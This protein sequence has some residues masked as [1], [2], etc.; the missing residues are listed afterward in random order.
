MSAGPSSHSTAPSPTTHPDGAP[1]P[2]TRSSEAARPGA[3]D[4]SPPTVDHRSHQAPNADPAPPPDRAGRAAEPGLRDPEPSAGRPSRRAPRPDP[5]PPADLA[6]P[7]A[8]AAQPAP[9]HGSEPAV[10]PSRRAPDADPGP[11]P[12]RSRRDVDAAQP[13]Q[14]P[15]QP[16]SGRPP[17]DDAAAGSGPPPPAGPG[18]SLRS[19]P[20]PPSHGSTLGEMASG[21]AG[22]EDRRTLG[23][24]LMAAAVLCFT[25]IDTSA[26]WL[27]LAGLP[28]LQV[29]FARYAGHFLLSLAA[30]M[31]S[32]G[33]GA[34]RSRRPWLQF[35]RSSF[36]L[37][38]TVLNFAALAYLPLTLT[39]TIM[40][41]GPIVV[42]LLSVPILGERIGKRRM[43][44]I[45]VGFAGVTIAVQPWGA[46]FHP[47]IG[48][49]IGALISASLYFVLTRLL[50]GIESNA[51]SQLWSSGLATLAIAPFAIAQWRWPE[52]AGGYA[53][54]VGIGVFGMIGHSLVTVASR[55]AD[56]ST[57]APV[58]Y[59]QFLFAAVAGIVVFATPP[60]VWTLLGGA[61]IVG[62][63]VYIWRRERRAA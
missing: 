37:G 8:G 17:R 52:T 26:K 62:S 33:P 35:L 41:A 39:T 36:L 1:A 18:L 43:A 10:H 30:F 29:V 45:V 34:F 57:L 63:G 50:A 60:T 40:F 51:T 48:L 27:I 49:S 31:P 22:R 21:V 11:P 61:V 9:V 24:G 47:A 55:F 6:H 53:V 59:I 14:L 20:V 3:V 46:G 44:A 23:L 7:P 56:A 13:I 42:S 15:E 19:A 28:A 32:E 16:P 54:L 5:E 38:S 58:V 25:F 4:G 12:N 2:A